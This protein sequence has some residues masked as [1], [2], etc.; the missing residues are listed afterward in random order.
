[1]TELIGWNKN[2][3]V[4]AEKATK[5][6]ETLVR[7]GKAAQAQANAHR[8]SGCFAEAVESDELHARLMSQAAL[9]VEAADTLR[10]NA[11]SLRAHATAA[12]AQVIRNTSDKQQKWNIHYR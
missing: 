9:A 8:S 11:E 4:D 1:M 12:G 6:V 2:I 10:A 7:D 5:R 3:G